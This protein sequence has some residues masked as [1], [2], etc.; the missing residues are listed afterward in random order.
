MLKK[1]RSFIFFFYAV[2]AAALLIASF[3]DLKLDIFLNNPDNPF[4]IWFANTGEIPSR[5]VFVAAGGVIFF[6]ADNK[7]LKLIGLCSEMCG[8]A[9]LGYYIAYYNFRDGYMIPFGIIF[10]IGT[11]LTFL[12]LGSLIKIPEELKKTLV[13]ISIAG[14]AVNFV[15][16]ELIETIKMFW[17]RVRF[18]DMITEPDYASFTAWFRPNGINGHKSFP[19]GHTASASMSYL[20]MLLPFTTKRWKNNELICF[21]IPFIYTSAV[22][23]TRL[24]MGAHFLSDVT[25]GGTIGFS[26]VIIAIIIL[27]KKQLIS[28]CNL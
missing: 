15:Q 12:Y 13:I 19:S 18:R 22:A 17:G 8:A 9:Y 21:I 26:S 23:F 28:S 6:A 1:Y 11:G 4:A 24:V 7:L 2:A 5:L 27:D 25:V 3:I 14:F 20:M 10:G 16:L